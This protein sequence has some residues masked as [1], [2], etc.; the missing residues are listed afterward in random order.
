MLD[1]GEC[2][3]L[4]DEHMALQGFASQLSQPVAMERAAH[5]AAIF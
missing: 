3:L 2:G 1:R 5:T 4:V